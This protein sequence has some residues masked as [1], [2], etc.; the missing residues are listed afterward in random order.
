MGENQKR[1]LRQTFFAA[2]GIALICLRD[3]IP[4]T[5]TDLEGA[6][7]LQNCLDQVGN[8]FIRNEGN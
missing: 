3:D 8:H 7:V 4:K 5:Y 6:M 1:Q 2:F